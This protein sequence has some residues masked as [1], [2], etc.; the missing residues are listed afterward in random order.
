MSRIYTEFYTSNGVPIWVGKNA[1]ANDIM[2]FHLAHPHDIWFHKA[3]TSGPHVVLHS[4]GA[5]I[6]QTD[7]NEAA[8]YAIPNGGQLQLKQ[9]YAV[10]YADVLSVEKNKYH[11]AGQ[12]ILH[13][14][15][16]LRIRV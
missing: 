2:T 7:L 16:T 3:D 14:F 13:Q 12:V 1:H 4:E 9:I 11:K 10:H 15:K 8:H 6:T 5:P